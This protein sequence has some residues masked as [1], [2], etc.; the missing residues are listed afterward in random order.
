MTTDSDPGD[1]DRRPIVTGELDLL[2]IMG[3]VYRTGNERS[4]VLDRLIDQLVREARDY[5]R[6]PEA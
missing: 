1:E 4:A 5:H 3:A 2:A 6:T